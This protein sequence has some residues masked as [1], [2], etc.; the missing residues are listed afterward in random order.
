[1]QPVTSGWENFFVAEAGAAETLIVL[2]SALA[3]DLFG[4][5][6]GQGASGLGLELLGTGL[7]V[8]M[9]A[10]WLQ[11]RGRQKAD[12]LYWTVTRVVTGQVPALGYLTGGAALLAGAPRGIY[13]LVPG[14]MLCFVGGLVNA[15]VLLIEILR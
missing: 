11:L 8:S 5:V 4:L 7:T 10:S 2:V 13:W 9:S 14:T 12:P 3:V 6:P 15:W 1:M